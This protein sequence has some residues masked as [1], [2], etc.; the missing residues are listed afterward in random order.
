MHADVCQPP[1]AG[2]LP[3][4]EALSNALGLALSLYPVFVCINMELW[5]IKPSHKLV[6]KSTESVYMSM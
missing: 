1:L 6:A 5:I 3:M 4:C 2:S